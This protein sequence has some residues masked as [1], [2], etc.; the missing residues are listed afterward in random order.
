VA[1]PTTIRVSGSV[2]AVVGSSAASEFQVQVP[3]RT[4]GGLT[5]SLTNL[6]NGQ[7]YLVAGSNVTITSA[8]NGQ[9]FISSTGGGGGSGADPGVS[10]ITLNATASLANERALSVS[11]TS[12][13]ILTDGGP[14][15]TAALSINN[16]VVATISG[17]NFSGPV[18]ATGGLTGSVQKLSSGLS[19][20]VAVGG[21]S[22]TSNSNGQ[23]LISGSGGGGGSDL[24]PYARL[25]GATFTGGL[26]GSIQRTSGGVSYLV[27]GG[28]ISITSSSNGQILI[29]SSLDPTIL[30]SLTSAMS[31]SSA[32]AGT[33]TTIFS[34]AMVS[35]YDAYHRVHNLK[36]RIFTSNSTPSTVVQYI[37][38]ANGRSYGVDAYLMCQHTSTIE[39]GRW[40]L[41]GHY[42][43]TAGV[44]VLITSDTALSSSNVTA[45]SGTLSSSAGN[46][47]VTGT[48]TSTGSFHWGCELRVQELGV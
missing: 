1:I 36:G 18:I 47:I 26:T 38:G 14:G 39:C 34:G 11:G 28:G 10:Y 32:G 31:Y 17:A 27:A 45:L 33:L 46:I 15:S 23:V 20:L 13:L 48:G 35:G 44:M 16:N 24:T 2:L 30:T 42:R 12:G 7:S 6:A 5:G 37:S 3:F 22:I 21:V 43:R 4:F 25:D 29:S 40:K 9:I 8:S 41:S 19:Y